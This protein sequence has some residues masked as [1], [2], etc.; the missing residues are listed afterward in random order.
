MSAEEYFLVVTY[1]GHRDS[2]STH[3]VVGARG[4]RSAVGTSSVDEVLSD[5]RGRRALEGWRT[6]RGANAELDKYRIAG[7]GATSNRKGYSVEVWIRT[8]DKLIPHLADRS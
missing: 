8:G 6:L 2:P 3:V 7:T 1:P 4:R 5:R